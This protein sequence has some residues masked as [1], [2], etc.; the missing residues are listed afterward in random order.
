MSFLFLLATTPMPAVIKRSDN[1]FYSVS[2]VECNDLK[3]SWDTVDSTTKPAFQYCF[4]LH[5]QTVQ[6]TQTQIKHLRIGHVKRGHVLYPNF[7]YKLSFCG[8]L[9]Q[10]KKILWSGCPHHWNQ[11]VLSGFVFVQE[12]RMTKKR[13]RQAT[14]KVICVNGKKLKGLFPEFL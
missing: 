6:Q 9:L 12:Q 11:G 8:H 5:I 3:V 14:Q 1:W 2:L 10:A 13:K 4:V 7:Y